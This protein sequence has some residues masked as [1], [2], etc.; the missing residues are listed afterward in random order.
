[1]GHKKIESFKN[2]FVNLALPFFA[3]SEP[4]PPERKKVRCDA[5]CLE[6]M[7][8]CACATRVTMH[9]CAHM[10]THTHTHTHIHT[11]TFG[12]VLYLAIFTAIVT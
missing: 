8:T 11:H 5:V 10:H 1:M 2:S 9:V 12:L 6:H 4:L 7:Y 3:M